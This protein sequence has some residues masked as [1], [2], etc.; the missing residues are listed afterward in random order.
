MTEVDQRRLGCDACAIARMLLHLD[1]PPARNHIFLDMHYI[2]SCLK[3]LMSEWLS[4]KTS[5]GVNRFTRSGF[6]MSLAKKIYY[7]PK[8]FGIVKNVFLT[9]FIFL[10]ETR[11]RFRL[12]LC[13]TLL[14][15]RNDFFF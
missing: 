11:M 12:M 5:D 7:P 4:L 8:K 1:A 13:P 14:P 10:S 9:L 15:P 3:Q 6:E 2:G